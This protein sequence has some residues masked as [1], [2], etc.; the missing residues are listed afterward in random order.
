MND[1]T[2][3]DIISIDLSIKNS[4]KLSDTR[5]SRLETEKSMVTDSIER[6]L[7]YSPVNIRSVKLLKDKL[8][9]VQKNIEKEM[10]EELL[11]FYVLETAEIIEKYKEEMHKPIK[12]IPGKKQKINK[13]I[14]ELVNRYIKIAER[15][16][17]K[18]V[19]TK[20]KKDKLDDIGPEKILCEN[21]G[22]NK[23]FD[24]IDDVI[25]ICPKCFTQ[26]TLITYKSTYNDID[27][28]NL[29]NQYT[30]KREIHFR[31]CIKQYQGKQN[32]TIPDK[33]YKD[34]EKELELHYILIDNSDREI[35]FSKVTKLQLIIFMENLGYSEHYENV[36]LIHYV[37]TG[38][39]PDN[40]SHLEDIL[41]ND[42]KILIDTYDRLFPTK[43][44]K[45]GRNNFINA[46]YVLFQLLRL[47]KHPCNRDD[48]SLL[49]TLS[50]RAELDEITKELF[51]EIG[52]T[53][54]SSF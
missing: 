11:N 23:G 21:C 32:C 31:D 25:Y 38:K 15:Y 22:N 46:Q 41:I 10:S 49:K 42:F 14:L 48:F 39:K 7:I 33:V 5:L 2:L 8:D 18:Q 12:I 28:V 27:R 45:N 24:I 4:L 13:D 36:H 53:F 16:G 52:W 26:Q 54:T 44:S 17:Y 9:C 43:E 3:V 34:L 40:I 20:K 29:S 30:Y 35:R 19:Y 6:L 37:L 1:E 47:H 51:A 50:T